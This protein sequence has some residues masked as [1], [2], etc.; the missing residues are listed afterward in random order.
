MS[1]LAGHDIVVDWNETFP[2][3]VTWNSGTYDPTKPYK[4]LR[5]G[6]GGGYQPSWNEVNVVTNNTTAGEPADSSVFTVPNDVTSLTQNQYF[7]VTLGL[8]QDNNPLRTGTYTIAPTLYDRT[9]GAPITIASTEDASSSY[10]TSAWSWID[11]QGAYAGNIPAGMLL[12]QSMTTCV[13]ANRLVSGNV[14]T[15]DRLKD[16]TSVGPAQYGS[17][18]YKKGTQNYVGSFNP[19]WTVSS[20]VATDN[21]AGIRTNSNI[22]VDNTAGSSAIPLPTLDLIVKDTSASNAQL[23]STC[24]AQTPAKPT[25]TLN[26]TTS[27]RITWAKNSEDTNVQ[28]WDRKTTY[29]WSLFKQSDLT[30]PVMVRDVDMPTLTNGTY[31]ETIDFR[32]SMW[33]PLPVDLDTNYVIKLTASNQ[34][35]YIESPYSPASDPSMLQTPA[36]P[37]APT[38]DLVNP[39]KFTITWNKIASDIERTG[40]GQPSCG[41]TVDYTYQL[42]KASDLNTIVSSGGM[43]GSTLTGN[44]YSKTFE[45]VM[46]G[47]PTWQTVRLEGSVNY[48]VKIKAYDSTA[49]LDSAWSVASAVDSL[50]GPPAPLKPTEPVA[51]VTMVTAKLTMR[52]GETSN[53]YS[54]AVYNAADTTFSN[55]LT[56]TMNS[57]SSCSA[58]APGALTLT[59]TV[60]INNG[61]AT[62]NAPNMYVIRAF[63][64]DSN[65]LASLGSPASSEFMGGIPGVSV[66]NP[67]N[68]TEAGDA[69][70]WSE[71]FPGIIGS[72]TRGQVLPDGR[73]NYYSLSFDTTSDA[74][75]TFALRKLKADF[76]GFETGFGSGGKTTLTTLNQSSQ[77]QGS[78]PV[79]I[80]KVT[81]P[82]TSFFG[83]S[84]KIAA[85]SSVSNCAP[86]P[87][88][89]GSMSCGSPSTVV[90]M[91]ESTIGSAFSTPINITQK[92]MDFC[93]ANADTDIA[94]LTSANLTGLSGF[95]GFDRP[96]GQLTCS[97]YTNNNGYMNYAQAFLT[98]ISSDGTPTLITT[99]NTIDTNETTVTRTSISGNPAATGT[100][101]AAVMLV[102]RAKGS[103]GS[104]GTYS[105]YSRALIRVKADGTVVETPEAYSVVGTEP[106]VNLAPVNDGTTVYAVHSVN[107]VNKLLQTGVAT[108]TFNSGST[109]TL[110]VQT[111]MAATTLTFPR[112]SVPNVDVNDSPDQGEKIAFIRTDN[113]MMTRQ[114]GPM[115]YRLSDGAT[116]TG[117]RLVYSSSGTPLSYSDVNPAGNM[118]YVYTPAV[119][120]VS[121]SHKVIRWL[122]VRSIVPTPVP[123]VSAPGV[124]V[125]LNAG[126]GNVVITGVNLGLTSATKKVK[127]VRFVTGLTTG[128][129]VTTMTKTSTSITVKIPSA[130]VAGVPVTPSSASP[131]FAEIKLILGDDTEVYAGD[132]IYVGAAKMPQ[133]LTMTLSEAAATTASADRNISVQAGS[134]SQNTDLAEA[135][136]I[137]LPVLSATPASVCSIVEGKVRFLSNGNCLVK[138]TKAGNE[139]LADGVDTKT[140][141]VLKA[142]S[143]TAGFSAG[144]TPSEVMTADEAIAPVITLASGRT[145][146]TMTA[147][148][149]DI[150]EI[151]ADTKMIWFKTGN[152]DCVVTIA[153]PNATAV[154]AATTYTWTI[155][156]LPPAGG[157]GSP[158]LVRNDN[159]MVKLPGLGVRWDQKK[160]QVFFVTRVKWVG[161]VQAKMSFVDDKGTDDEADDVTYTCVSNF[162][163]LKKSVL[164]KNNEPFIISSGAM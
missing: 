73:G 13:L 100:Q 90:N 145:D 111:N 9:A 62:F 14:L 83:E 120:Q 132:L 134:I 139:W 118:V 26:S 64:T 137:G 149:E 82:S 88:M 66:A 146:Y 93:T 50:V 72:S 94:T 92:L 40:C 42:F 51:T 18:I 1:S 70:M 45:N 16:G 78:G 59:C 128:T 140:I 58:T 39:T 23:E 96:V 101:V 75:E 84:N 49:N 31:T 85:F 8:S 115:S 148:D 6:G 69:K 11:G 162:G 57:S 17:S 91:S 80:N 27:A 5:G 22:E 87:N 55:P 154:W 33:N 135:A 56:T 119:S 68:G 53:R 157:A 10:V 99:L 63:S 133:P 156:V 48:V 123:A 98:S 150:C 2:S 37:S 108:G 160:N 77:Y 159:V 67:S 79:T 61:M 155:P 32:D 3:G 43:F 86:N 89:P 30:T 151:N 131:G 110:D 21:W 65:G 36:A 163:I 74:S 20:S 105:N 24:A 164:P 76:T 153:T 81:M 158:L 112:N 34:G 38:L 141:A 113:V 144:E 44:S 142:D 147:A 116:V 71:N 41:R 114:I 130:S 122:N 15:V 19:N 136:P 29:K 126:G 35:D 102:V 46:S 106:T 129:T 124:S 152:E 138:A 52:A 47:P 95:T 104:Y 25:F 107:G 28:Y 117:E 60:S 7:S 127:G 103:T 97:G 12:T 121:L 4:Y 54:I 161:P 143:V 125:S 109:I